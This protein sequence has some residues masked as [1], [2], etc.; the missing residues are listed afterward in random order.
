MHLSNVH[1]FIHYR[2]QFVETVQLKARLRWGRVPTKCLHIKYE[3]L[4]LTM[5]E[6]MATQCVANTITR[7]QN[8]NNVL[9]MHDLSTKTRS[10]T[11]IKYGSH[12]THLYHTLKKMNITHHSFCDDG[13]D[14]CQIMDSAICRNACAMSTCIGGGTFG[15]FSMCPGATHV[16]LSECLN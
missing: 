9:V 4:L 2:A 13:G 1:S 7:H 12:V 3:K 11:F 14:Y 6:S 5:D 8:D 15:Y 10:K 16:K